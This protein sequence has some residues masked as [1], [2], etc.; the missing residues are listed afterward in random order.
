MDE[1]WVQLQ[2]CSPVQLRLCEWRL[3]CKLP[4][5]L[6]AYHLQL[7]VLDWVERLL[8]PRFDLMAAD[9]D[10]DAMGPVS[11]VFPGVV[12]IVE[13]QGPEQATVLQGELEQMVA[14][15]DYLGNG[16]LWC[17]D[18]RD[19][20]I[21]YLDHDSSPLLTRVFAEAGEYLDALTVTAMCRAF[22]IAAGRDD[23]DEHAEAMLIERFGRELVRKWMY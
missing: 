1:E 2:P 10:M 14:F 9:D 7:G 6:R 8:N 11:V 21:W 20:S 13:M 16:N 3:G 4:E 12:D 22:A 17:F 19:A 15:G 18:R 23:G 5:A